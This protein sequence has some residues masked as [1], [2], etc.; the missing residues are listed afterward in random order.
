MTRSEIIYQQKQPYIPSYKSRCE[1]WPGCTNNHCKYYHPFMNCR[2]GKSCPFGKKCI[3]LH[4]DDC[5]DYQS[6]KKQRKIKNNQQDNKKN[7][8]STARKDKDQQHDKSNHKKKKKSINK[9]KEDLA[10]N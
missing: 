1:F 2:N 4:P 9:K 3:F 5:F 6:I 8:Q 7:Q 10:G